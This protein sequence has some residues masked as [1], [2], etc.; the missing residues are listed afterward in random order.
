MGDQNCRPENVD[1]RNAVYFRL[2]AKQ[3]STVTTDDAS[4]AADIADTGNMGKLWP[5][6]AMV[7]L[8]HSRKEASGRKGAKTVDRG[9]RVRLS[10]VETGKNRE[11][12]SNRRYTMTQ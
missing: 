9:E 3:K 1:H 5:D 2:P 4:D 6:R 12:N 11:N 10:E 8:N 7:P